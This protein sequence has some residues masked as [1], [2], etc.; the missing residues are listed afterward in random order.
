LRRV[1][2]EVTGLDRLR[3]LREDERVRRLL[4]S[5]AVLVPPLVGSDTVRPL[6]TATKVLAE[7]R[8]MSHCLHSYLREIAAGNY[9]AYSVEW[10]GQQT[11][12]GLVRVGP[13]SVFTVGRQGDP[14]RIDQVQ[15]PGNRHPSN[16]LMKHVREW[17]AR[18]GELPSPAVPKPAEPVEPVVREEQLELVLTG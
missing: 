4:D 3:Q 5:D 10:Q 15:G 8:R 2:D 12:V 13:G 9:Y 18:V 17:F 14:W 7:G 6:D 1:H 16:G 11:T